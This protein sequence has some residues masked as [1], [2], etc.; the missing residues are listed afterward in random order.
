M[1]SK[2]RKSED[3]FIDVSSIDEFHV[4]ATYLKVPTIPHLMN[5]PLRRDFHPSFAIYSPNSCKVFYKDFSTKEGGS[6]WT[7]LHKKWGCSYKEVYRRVAKDLGSPLS[8]LYP[9]KYPLI[10]KTKLECK[11]R[12]WKAYDLKYWSS[13][14]VSKEWLE[15]ADVYPISHKIIIKNNKRILFHADKY[16]Y[17]FVEFKEDKTTLKIYQPF[18]TKGQ[19]W[20]CSHDKSVISLWTK[21]PAE[22]EYICICSSL[23][24]AL[25]LWSNTGIPAIALQGEGYDISNTALEVLKE[26]F[27]HIFICF[28]NDVAGLKFSAELSNITG[29]T[30]VV[31]PPFTGGKDI[32]D[33]YKVLQNKEEFRK[34]II[35]CFK[36]SYGKTTNKKRGL[37]SNQE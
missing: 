36:E 29:F 18:N 22:G 31:L 24:D 19:K 28:D 32:S 11:V 7:L 6:I 25:C 2:G 20:S 30:N 12:D 23:K 4:A 3:E 15:Y 5:S 17:C 14:G 16:A 26:R 13:Y 8:Y 1:I 35:N 9:N 21:V 10:S 33:L 34:I 37:F 27:K